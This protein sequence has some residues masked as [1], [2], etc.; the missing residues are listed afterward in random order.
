MNQGTN[1][2]KKLSKVAIERQLMLSPSQKNNNYLLINTE[3]SNIAIAIWKNCEFD[4]ALKN[5]PINHVK[6][7]N[8]ILV[9]LFVRI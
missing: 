8:T 6:E 4:I 2:Y 3:K 1:R 7:L 9:S 5:Q